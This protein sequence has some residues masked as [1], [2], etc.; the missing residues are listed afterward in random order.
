[1][2]VMV[3]GRRAVGAC[4][5][6]A[7]SLSPSFYHHHRRS[8]LFLTQPQYSAKVHISVSC[9]CFS[10]LELSEIKARLLTEDDDLVQ[11][12]DEPKQSRSVDFLRLPLL[13]LVTTIL[14]LLSIEEAILFGY[15]RVRTIESQSPAAHRK[16]LQALF[17]IGRPFGAEPKCDASR[18]RNNC[19]SRRSIVC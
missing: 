5:A 4:R 13:P 16:E 18:L 12:S 17:P 3:G 10:V 14:E 19:Q 1:M 7:V 15:R 2:E 8:G 11:A 9:L 6:R